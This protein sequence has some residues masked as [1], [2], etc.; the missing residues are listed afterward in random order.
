MSQGQL[1]LSHLHPVVANKR[2]LIFSYPLDQ[3]HIAAPMV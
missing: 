1:S 3:N 2:C